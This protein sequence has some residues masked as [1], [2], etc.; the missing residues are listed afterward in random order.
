[1]DEHHPE[2]RTDPTDPADPVDPVHHHAG[3]GTDGSLESTHDRQHEPHEG[4]GTDGSL[5]SAKSIE[6]D[7][8]SD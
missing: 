3:V 2:Q 5:H 1:M 6:D 7:N 4:G 8:R